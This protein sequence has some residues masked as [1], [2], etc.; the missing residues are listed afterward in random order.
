MIIK[1]IIE[2]ANSEINIWKELKNSS[3]ISDA[4]LKE[5]INKIHLKEVIKVAAIIL[6]WII[7]FSYIIIGLEIISFGSINVGILYIIP[8]FLAILI[9]LNIKKV[10]TSEII[11]RTILIFIFTCVISNISISKIENNISNTDSN[12]KSDNNFENLP[13]NYKT[14]AITERKKYVMRGDEFFN[15]ISEIIEKSIPKN[16]I[17]TG[18]GIRT[19]FQY[20]IVDITSSKS[21]ENTKDEAEKVFEKMFNEFR[22]NDYVSSNIFSGADYECV[23]VYFY[24]NDNTSISTQFNLSKINDYDDFESFDWSKH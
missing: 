4:I 13:D 9:L 12:V 21:K 20:I 11:P 14:E 5:K 15:N 17:F 19:R 22:K 8:G 16:S 1:K 7:A 3:K 18:Y 23:N 10:K 6:A 2:D 24:C